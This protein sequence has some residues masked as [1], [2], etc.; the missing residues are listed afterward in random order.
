MQPSI[1]E[2]N[3]SGFQAES[4]IKHSSRMGAAGKSCGAWEVGKMGTTILSTLNLTM[5][6]KSVIGR[7]GQVRTVY[8]DLKRPNCLDEA[9]VPCNIQDGRHYL[10]NVVVAELLE[11]MVQKELIVTVVLDSC[12]SG[13]TVRGPGSRGPVSRGIGKVDHSELPKS[14]I[15]WNL[16]A[17]VRSHYRDSS[18]RH[19]GVGCWNQK[20]TNCLPL[21]ILRKRS[22]KF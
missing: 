13:S 20:A 3:S 5:V 8:E 9:I 14:D 17:S 15:P 7:G 19:N 21:A 2:L 6:W 1:E 10:R 12:H 11:E 4:L 22:V 18:R 16:L